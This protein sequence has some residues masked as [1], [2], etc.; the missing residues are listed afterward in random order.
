LDW[1]YCDNKFPR[2][3]CI[4]NEWYTCVEN[5]HARFTTDSNYFCGKL[6]CDVLQDQSLFNGIGQYHAAEILDRL[7]I[8]Q[9]IPPWA[10]ASK[11]FKGCF[12][13]PN[14]IQFFFV[15][16]DCISS[17]LTIT[18]KYEYCP[19]IYNHKA[20]VEYLQRFIKVY[21]RPY[22]VHSNIPVYKYRKTKPKGKI[23]YSRALPP[24]YHLLPN[25]NSIFVEKGSKPNTLIPISE[26]HNWYLYTLPTSSQ[27]MQITTLN[28]GPFAWTSIKAT[29]KLI[30][31]G[32]CI[33]LTEFDA[34]KLL[35]LGNYSTSTI[36][37]ILMKIYLPK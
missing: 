34:R 24:N 15:I 33:N 20:S 23:I 13:N 19:L 22:V 6:L 31:L 37:V 2:G 10:L 4:I 5:F 14:V 16:R 27:H 36:E 18:D 29:C 1:G 28:V 11:Y 7:F 32:Q 3:P 25:D 12:D 30:A 21:R 35:V 9:E 17:M 26:P 8:A